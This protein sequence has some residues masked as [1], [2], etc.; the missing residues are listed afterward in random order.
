[1]IV[2][3]LGVLLIVAILF[4]TLI[5]SS[6]YLQV[7]N[8]NLVSPYTDE[9][10]SAQVLNPNKYEAKDYN[11]FEVKLEAT[12]IDTHDAHK[13]TFELGVVKNDNTK[14]LAP[15]KYSSSDGFTYDAQSSYMAYASICV[16]ANWVGV[17]DYSSSYS[18]ITQSSIEKTMENTTEKTINVTLKENEV[19][20]MKTSNWP[21]PITVK[22]PDA[23]V[24]LVYFE[25]INGEQVLTC[26]II[27]Y[28]YNEFYV[29]G[30][31]SP[32]I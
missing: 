5:G 19:F 32:A 24:L 8:N 4:S 15:I 30:T 2:G 31:T 20:P 29:A 16:A 18:Y 9:D 6:S 1:M 13:A 21:V 25:Q 14:T 28:S 22:T 3:I 12:S 23:Y 7:H 27:H 11:K 10:H 26:D 17:C